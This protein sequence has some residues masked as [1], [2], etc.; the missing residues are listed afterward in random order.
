[1]IN[2]KILQTVIHLAASEIQR[3]LFEILR[4]K[5]IRTHGRWSAHFPIYS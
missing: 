5:E 1:M 2:I 3:Y 4:T